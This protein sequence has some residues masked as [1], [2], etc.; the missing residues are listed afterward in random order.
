MGKDLEKLGFSKNEA[1]VYLALA[2]LGQTRAGEVI[3]KTGLH[4]NLVYQALTSLQERNLVTKS[5]VGKVAAFQV[6][7]P[8][9]LLDL[10]RDQEL[11]AERV[12]DEL[13]RTR[14]ITAQEIQVYEGEEA[15]RNYWMNLAK[16]L[17]GDEQLH[18]IG[19]GGALFQRIMGRTM[20]HYF[21]ELARHGGARVLMHPEQQYDAS[22]HR[23][24]DAGG[25]QVR[26]LEM[27]SPPSVT[28][29][30]TDRVVCFAFYAAAQPAIIQIR[31]QSLVEVYRVYFEMLWNQKV[32]VETGWTAFERS[33]A[34]II[35][36][37]EPGEIQYSLGASDGGGSERYVTFYE[38]HHKRRVKKGVRIRMLSYQEFTD[39]IRSRFV[40]AGDPDLAVSEIKSLPGIA[41]GLMEVNMYKGR[42]VIEIHGDEPTV[43]TINDDEVYKGMR[44]Y[45]D[46][47]WNMTSVTYRG[48]VGAKIF[49]G[50]LLHETD[51]YWI[52]GNGMLEK[53][54]PEVWDWYKKEHVKRGTIRWHDLIDPGSML[55][56]TK[57]G[58]MF[59]DE[60]GTEYKYLPSSVA[61]PHVMCIYGNKVANIV[62]SENSV[63][64]IV[65]DAEIAA[66]HR[67]YFQHLWD[68]NAVT[69]TGES[70]VEALL[71]RVLDVGQDL[72]L[73]AANGIPYTR[74]PELYAKFTRG[75][76]KKNISMHVVAVPSVR[77]TAFAKLPKM[78]IRYLSK[79]FESPMV[80][81]VFGNYVATVLWNWPVTICLINDQATA[82]SYRQH[83]NALKA[84]AKL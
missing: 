49:M 44:Q 7:D 9:C 26:P 30:F 61:S 17:E 54:H 3:G 31:N 51:V 10:I 34:A 48:A 24:A 22:G 81:W 58:S 74:Y 76:V 84:T 4:R 83:Y 29:G 39:R 6:A 36:R 15:I 53:F 78:I 70:G 66:S 43:I 80:V 55:T 12:I 33:Y 67:K 8:Q 2:S 25:V 13:Q 1:I 40:R 14:Q 11:T 42:V 46:D 63:I 68:Q 38:A 18:I 45:F 77:G 19:S 52:G 32:R 50:E 65:E 57:K 41:F 28:I 23:Y 59:Y 75:R 82:D 27:P 20:P 71:R 79:D 56:G 35:E 37:L 16:K 73:I 64:N 60:L 72:Y 62:W 5:M 21:A 47:Y 69:L